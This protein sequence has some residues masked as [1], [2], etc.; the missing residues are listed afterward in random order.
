MELKQQQFKLTRELIAQAQSMVT[1][2]DQSMLSRLQELTGW[3]VEL[4]MSE[5][6]REFNYPVL[7]FQFHLSRF[8]LL[9]VLPPTFR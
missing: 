9:F 1:N 7:C 3:D 2:I 5:L 4:L 6:G 8:K